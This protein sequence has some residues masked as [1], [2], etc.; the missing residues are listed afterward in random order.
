MLQV[1]VASQV[2]ALLDLGGP[3]LSH[4]MPPVQSYKPFERELD[5]R[6]ALNAR[7]TSGMPPLAMVPSQRLRTEVRQPML[8]AWN[9]TILLGTHH[10]SGTVLLAKVFRIAAKVFAVPRHKNNYTACARLFK[11]RA[12][13][14]C[15]DEHVNA[16]SMREWLQPQQPFI[17]AVRHPLE[18]CVSAY[19]Y[20]K[21]GAEP[22]LLK[23]LQDFGGVSL[24]QHY[25]SVDPAEG[26]RFEC[27]R[28]VT[29]LVES[30]ILYNRAQPPS[31]APSVPAAICPV[32]DSLVNLRV[33]ASGTHRRRNVLSIRFEEFDSDFD[34]AFSRIFSFLD[35]GAA[36]PSLLKEAAQYDLKRAQPGDEKH[37]SASEDK[38]PLRAFILGDVLLHSLLDSL[39][40]LLGYTPGRMVGSN[41]LCDQLRAL[42]ATTN[43]RFLQWCL[44]GRVALGQIA[45]LPECGEDSRPRGV[46]APAGFL[47]SAEW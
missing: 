33:V 32:M 16:N 17:H 2:V 21:Q 9:S 38:A 24:V 7:D 41:E 4:A 11:T 35:S 30:A 46:P 39:S 18:M 10:K 28:M 15:I 20:H 31:T 26:V 25:K 37:V 34:D 47:H 44:S 36:I 23:P 14:I 42:C 43:V 40:T 13:G 8:G 27:R 19:I 5:A 12:R 45:S 6:A 1:A 3:S 29:E 22:W